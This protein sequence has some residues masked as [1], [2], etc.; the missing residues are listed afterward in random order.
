MTSSAAK[1]SLRTVSMGLSVFIAL[2]EAS[3]VTFLLG[4]LAGAVVLLAT[5][6]YTAV[7]WRRVK[8]GTDKR[9]SDK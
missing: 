5:M 4:W 8:H 9:R 2:A 6:T 3:V 1:E 7:H